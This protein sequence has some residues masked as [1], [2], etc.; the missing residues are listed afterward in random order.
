MGYTAMSPQFADTI[1]W[2]PQESDH[3]HHNKKLADLQISFM[4][5]VKSQQLLYVSS[6]NRINVDAKSANQR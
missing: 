4:N 6:T 1:M 5:H 2:V 3:V